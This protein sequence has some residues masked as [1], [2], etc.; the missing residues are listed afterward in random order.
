MQLTK[1]K[2]IQQNV[3]PDNCKIIPMELNHI[4]DVMEID[5]SYSVSPWSRE[6]FINELKNQF[7][8][9]FV[10]EYNFE[11][12]GFMNFW[13]IGD[14]IELNNFAIKEIYCVPTPTKPWPQLGFQLA[15]V[16]TQRGYNGGITM[17]YSQSM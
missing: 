12:I 1:F 11:I 15:A 8:Y 17:S 13:L 7:S 2:G 5:A 14:I 9:N 10:L 3:L 6:L 4:D 16:H